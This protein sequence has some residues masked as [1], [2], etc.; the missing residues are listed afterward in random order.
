MRAEMGI[1]E[2]AGRRN[3]ILA[4]VLSFSMLMVS[5]A[6]CGNGTASGNADVGNTSLNG[7]GSGPSAGQEPKSTAMGRYV[8]EVIDLSDQIGYGNQLY[9][10]ENGD[11][12]ISD[13]VRDFLV[14]ADNGATW[15]TET[16]VRDWK[17]PLTENDSVMSLAV[18]ADNTVVVIYDAQSVSSSDE[19]YNPFD[20]DLK[21]MI[22]R[23]DGMQIPVE[24]P[25]TEEDE[26]LYNVWISD[27]G[28]ILVSTY[29][30]NLYEVKE[31][32]SS[33]VFLTLESAPTLIQFQN[34][35]M[36]IDGWDYGELLIYDMEERAY[37]EDS[38]LSDFLKENY[39]ERSNN[40]G[41]FY[42][43][44]FFM[45]EENILY[46]AG[47]KGLY[48]HVIGGSAIEQVI[49]GNL[50]VFNNPSYTIRGML[51]LDNSEFIALFSGGEVVRFTYNPD[52]PTV[53]DEKLKVYSLKENAT[54]RQAV[55]LYQ[56][57]YPEVYVEYEVGMEED[58]SVTRDD[59]LK[60]LNTRMMAEDGPDVLILDNMPMDSYMEKGLL[61][62]IAPVLDGMDGD[63]A[64]FG[65]LV[66][67]FRTDGHVYMMPAE[68]QIPI[69]YG[70]ESY[71]SGMTKLSGIADAMEAL[72]KDVPGKDLLGICSGT[73]IM[74]LFSMLS[75]PFWKTESG[76]ID[77][78]ALEDYLIQVKRIYDAQMDGLSDEAI[79][80]Y[81]DMRDR[82]LEEGGCDIDDDSESNRANL[83][84]IDYFMG[85]RGII[86]SSMSGAYEYAALYSIAR[87]EGYEDNVAVP[88]GDG[89]FYPKTLAGISAVSGNVERAEGFLRLLLGEENQSSLYDGFAV[90]R[91]AF[92]K[93]RRDDIGEDETYGS[94]AM[95]N[96]DG[97]LF[98]L[99]V[100][101]PGEEQI[102]VLR[103][104]IETAS[105]P[106]IEDTVLEEAVYEAGAAYLQ[107]T[108][109]LEETLDAVEK[110]AA[111]YIAE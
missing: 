80:E 44:F 36:I 6:G 57:A 5:L 48:R 103:N 21:L 66:D 29:G 32:G 56:I 111:L 108:K 25:L 64:L 46:L 62:D 15:E 8:E 93:I 69:A 16:E 26:H 1:A 87:M 86:C 96:E 85:Q 83:N 61:V 76:G 12:L 39:K 42:D 98:K 11:L 10:M 84:Y 24:I 65:N 91:A 79:Q 100:Y 73:G 81:N 63:D 58:S 74:R 102:G 43:L 47:H 70:K 110:K 2:N 40:G 53:P 35:L 82:I 59:A 4:A 78:E 72:R 45:G 17:A 3:R 75:V 41:S 105:V 22:I 9:Q 92:D 60:S 50:S 7:N 13:H 49:D 67:A 71:V 37:I 52:I 14:S 38:V 95:L 51:A 28:K 99:N 54:V 31:D 34:N 88:L 97:Q 68:I 106:Y 89:I 27:K 101:W 20:M 77:R 18:G 107:G 55:T 109:S 23:P 30:P 104:W 90:N 94:L 33:E 19:N